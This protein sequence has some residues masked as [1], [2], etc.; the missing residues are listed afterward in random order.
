MAKV[1]T[2]WQPWASLMAFNKKKIETRCWKT[3]YRGEL[4]I[5]SSKRPFDEC[6][7]R[8]PYYSALNPLHSPKSTIG[9]IPQLGLIIAKANLV[10]CSRMIGF[11]RINGIVRPEYGMRLENN[12][13]I[14][15]NTE[16]YEFGWYSIGRYAWIFEGIELLENPIPAK[17]AQRIW[18][19]TKEGERVELHK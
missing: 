9:L 12:M 17:G 2:L 19:Y 11:N 15:G 7:Y 3:D 4:Y 18:N 13:V 16:E 6:S 14:D 1:I 5:H 10:D 8:E